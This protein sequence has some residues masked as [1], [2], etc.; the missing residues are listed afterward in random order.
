[1][2][3]IGFYQATRAARGGSIRGSERTPL[4][5]FLKN[6]CHRERIIS[7]IEAKLFILYGRF[8]TLTPL[9]LAMMSM[10]LVSLME[11]KGF[12]QCIAANKQQWRGFVAAACFGLVATCAFFVCKLVFWLPVATTLLLLVVATLQLIVAA[13]LRLIVCGLFATLCV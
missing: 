1:M 4:D 12:W 9:S 13:T 10:V 8:D 2:R 11:I 6:L 3:V 5:F 7:H